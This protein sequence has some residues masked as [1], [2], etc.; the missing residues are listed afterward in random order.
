MQPAAATVSQ[1]Q[2]TNDHLGAASPIGELTT[3]D[4]ALGEKTK[5]ETADLIN[6]TQKGLGGIR[7]SLTADEKTTTVQIHTFLETGTTGVG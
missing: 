3:G 1:T 2:A 5:H 7:R 6:D 4:V